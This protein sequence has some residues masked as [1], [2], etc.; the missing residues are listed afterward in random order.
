MQ[1]FVTKESNYPRN[2]DALVNAVNALLKYYSETYIFFVL[3][4]IPIGCLGIVGNIFCI[5]V[6]SRAKMRSSSIN[7][8]LLCLAFWDIVAIIGI[9]GAVGSYMTLSYL[10]TEDVP[11]LDHFDKQRRFSLVCY[12]MGETGILF[13]FPFLYRKRILSL[14]SAQHAS[15]GFTLLITLER[16]IYGTLLK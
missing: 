10:F 1:F 12:A 4:N 5:I 7:L 8:L 9:S 11:F 6:F 2:M 15:N 13:L 16:C 3:V 14:I